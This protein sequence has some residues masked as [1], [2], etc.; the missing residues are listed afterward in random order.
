MKSVYL[1]MNHQATVKGPNGTT[2]PFNA[3]PG[4]ACSGAKAIIHCRIALRGTLK[5]LFLFLVAA[6]QLF[7]PA[8]SFS[9]GVLH[10]FPPKLHDET[11]AVARP[12]VLRSVTL[13]TVSESS[14]EYKVDQTFLNNNDL[15]IEGVFVF[16]FPKG[17]RP[18]DGD[19]RVDGQSVPFDIASA[20]SFF[21]SLRSWAEAANDPSLLELAGKDVLMIRPLTMSAHQ[22]RSFRVVFRQPMTI[23]EDTSE[24]VVPLAGERYSLGPVGTLEIVARFK[25]SRPVRT[26]FSTTHHITVSREAP[27]RCLVIAKAEQQRVRDD[28]HLL[29]TY[30]GEDI[31]F[32]VFTHK[33][34]SERGTFGV[35]IEPPVP[36]PGPEE[37]ERD[38][39]FLVDRSGSI[40]NAQLELA[41]RAVTFGLEKL[42]RGDRFNVIAIGSHTDKLSVRL[43]DPTYG[44]I[45]KAIRFV[46]A[47]PSEGGTDLY[48]ALM[49]ALE[50]F[51]SRKRRSIMVLIGDGRATIGV[52]DP[53]IILED[54]KRNNVVRARFCVLA[55]GQEADIALLDRIATSGRGNMSHFSENQDFQSVMSKFF[56]GIS[57]PEVTEL[58]L[59][60]QNFSPEDVT[61]VTISDTSGQE[62]AVVLGRY[63]DKGNT[64]ATARLRARVR[65]KVRT[66]TR[67]FRLPGTDPRR[68]YLPTLWAMRQIAGN[69]E[70]ELLRR[71]RAKK[72]DQMVTLA[73]EFGLRLPLAM[74]PDIGPHPLDLVR[75]DAAELLWR[76]KTFNVINQLQA[77]KFRLVNGILFQLEKGVWVDTRYRPAMTVRK[78]GFL[79]DEYFELIRQTPELGAY[80]SLGPEVLV[81]LDKS[82]IAVARDLKPER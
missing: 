7:S 65:G 75:Q 17:G 36:S 28:F 64:T 12:I 62:G 49:A 68:A 18:V 2:S 15:P 56:A 67:S 4:S 79:S 1:A 69:L 48:N 11:F 10:V 52:T 46:N 51:P 35:F 30:S 73:R 58:S 76:F 60:F 81:V 9:G 33:A 20:S 13:V 26:V 25:M 14:I 55:L 6:S 47:R 63:K 24:V 5:L 82:A 22:Q 34:A 19:V 38:I 78:A 37:P 40:G 39:V 41:R 61:P 23:E 70:E 32:R 57:Q 21:P 3:E 66:I 45:M 59:T 74:D 77:D 72:V 44:N 54:T 53:D 71:P 43:L 29:T 16:P 42:R 27:H 80:L 50:Q 8:T 31:D